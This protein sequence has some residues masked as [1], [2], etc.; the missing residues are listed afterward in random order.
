MGSKIQME[1]CRKVMVTVPM[2]LTFDPERKSNLMH[3]ACGSVTVSE[4]DKKLGDVR[5]VWAAGVEVNIFE[6]EDKWEGWY[7][8]P[9]DLFMAAYEATQ[10][11]QL[12]ET[13]SEKKK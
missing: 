4:D 6:N 1:D 8:S 2:Y 11:K 10:G 5:I 3:M 12:V 9:K 13:E 7:L